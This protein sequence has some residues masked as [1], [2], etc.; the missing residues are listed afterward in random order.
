[1]KLSKILKLRC[2]VNTFK[3]SLIEIF[4]KIK[5]DWNLENLLTNWCEELWDD[6]NEKQ[7]E[8][9]Y[10]LYIE[11]VTDIHRQDKFE[12]K[13]F[14]NKLILVKGNSDLKEIIDKW[15]TDLIEE[16]I[17]QDKIKSKEVAERAST[18]MSRNYRI[19]KIPLE[20]EN[21]SFYDYIYKKYIE[22]SGL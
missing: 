15:V 19:L 5:S 20:L 1:M 11:F 6:F 12:Q 9:L 2:R 13:Q 17:K 4:I 22:I 3:D 7:K 16:D 18:Y 10:K 14:A 8:E 21:D